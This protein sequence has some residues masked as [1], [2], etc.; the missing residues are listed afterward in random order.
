MRNISIADSSS[1]FRPTDASADGCLVEHRSIPWSN[2]GKGERH[3]IVRLALFYVA[4]LAGVGYYA[5]QPSY[6][7]FGSFWFRLDGVCVHNTTGLVSKKASK[8]L[9]YPNP[10]GER[11]PKWITT[12]SDDSSEALDV[13]TLDSILSLGD[14]TEMDGNHYYYYHD[15]ETD[16]VMLITRD[17][18]VI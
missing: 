16:K 2:H 15:A 13:L 7:S 5:P 10:A 12:D 14:V 3:L 6:P 11:G 9:E 8:P 4:G 17:T 1:A 18:P